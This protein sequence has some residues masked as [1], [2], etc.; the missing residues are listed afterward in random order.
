MN[1]ILNN[2]CISKCINVADFF[3]GI[4]TDKPNAY[5]EDCIAKQ[6]PI[7]KVSKHDEFTVTITVKY[8][9]F[10]ECKKLLLH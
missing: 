4:D 6:E 10:M 7:L 2:A 9:I 3:K 5:I 1:R 8:F